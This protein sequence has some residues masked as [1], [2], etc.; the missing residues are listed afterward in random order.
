MVVL[1]QAYPAMQVCA[2]CNGALVGNG[3][4]TIGNLFRGC[5][6]EGDRTKLVFAGLVGLS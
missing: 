5:L 3:S 6:G 4:G 2:S 1:E